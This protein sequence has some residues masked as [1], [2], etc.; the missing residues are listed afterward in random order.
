MKNITIF[1]FALLCLQAK[2]QISPDRIRKKIEDVQKLVSPFCANELLV[3]D[4]NNTSGE[5][6]KVVTLSS[7]K[8][9]IDQYFTY[10]S[11]NRGSL[12]TG[13]SAALELTNNSTLI[14]LSLSK[15][16]EPRSPS[17]P[18]TILTGGIKASI[19]DGISQLF[20]GS[21]LNTGTTLFGNFAFLP[22][23]TR[24]RKNIKIEVSRFLNGREIPGPYKQMKRDRQLHAQQFC[25]Y[26]SKGYSE[27]YQAL[28]NRW[29]AVS[30]Q[31][32]NLKPGD[33][34]VMLNKI[35]DDVEKQLSDAGLLKQSASKL[36]GAMKKEYENRKYDLE[37]ETESWLWVKFHWFSGGIIYTRQSYDT[38]DEKQSL[39]KRF[40]SDIFDE[41]GLNFTAHWFRE[42]M[43][44]P[45]FIG[46]SYFNIGYEPRTTNNYIVLKNKDITSI[47]LRSASPADTVYSFQSTKK[48]KNITG[49]AYESG[50][51]HKV[52]STFTAMLGEK[53]NTGVNLRGEWIP[54]DLMS[55]VYNAHL[56][57]L[58]RFVNNNYDPA[59]KKSSSKLNLE[60]FIEFNDMSDVGMSGKSVWQNKL[61]GI[62]TSVPF[63]KVFFK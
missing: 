56:G 33:D 13:N 36:A 12:P 1:L 43:N 20:S 19:S 25:R 22:S 39:A 44:E 3:V 31:L 34:T 35:K 28:I 58:L 26:A 47:I 14:N 55:P 24:Y 17:G 4:T 63:N 54:S 29:E 60:F 10:L 30:D 23:R 9:Y 52:R 15:K 38:Y 48:A 2:A 51:Q 41:I 7:Y 45:G 46:S 37:T 6:R 16:I 40:D 61:I 57:V 50:W 42:R 18:M 59:D 62:S 49:K 53:Q 32:N 8:K 21:N 11:Y 27:K 5:F